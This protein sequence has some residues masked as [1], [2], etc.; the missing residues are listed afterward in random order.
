MA[1][2]LYLWDKG[3]SSLHLPRLVR[4]SNILA[5]KFLCTRITND[6]FNCI[7]RL[8]WSNRTSALA[9]ESMTGFCER[10]FKWDENLI[11]STVLFIA[12]GEDENNWHIGRMLWINGRSAVE[13]KVNLDI[14]RKVIIVWG[15]LWTIDDVHNSAYAAVEKTPLSTYICSSEGNSCSNT[16][17]NGGWR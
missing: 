4:Q 11:A 1:E 17:R 9:L 6:P 8:A 5:F 15:C 13:C 14:G 2:S 16:D 10:E 12:I 7:W 3:V